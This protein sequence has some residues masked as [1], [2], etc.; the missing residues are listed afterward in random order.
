MSRDDDTIAAKLDAARSPPWL[1]ECAHEDGKP[2]AN[3]ANAMIALRGA[4]ELRDAIARDEMRVDNMLMQALP[5]T[6]EAAQLFTPRP[7][8]DI[9][10]ARIQELL[11]LAGLRRLS[12]DVLRQAIEMRGHERAFHQVRDY[13]EHLEWDLKPRL[14][15]WLPRYLGAAPSPYIA[16]VGTMFLIAMV[17]RVMRPG[18]KADYMLVLEGPQGVGKSSACRILGGDWYSDNLPSLE[19]GKEA[20]QHLRGLWLVEV[21]EL[22]AFGRS[23]SAI[24]KSFI[25]RQAERYRPPHGHLEVTEP[26]QC[27]LIGTVND[28]LALRD[29][30][31][32]RRFWPVPVGSIDLDALAE[33]R[34]QLFAEALHMYREGR[35][36]YPDRDFE[37][38]HIKPVQADRLEGDALEEVVADLLRHTSRTTTAELIQRLGE[39]NP[40][41]VP[42]DAARRIA[43]ILQRQGWACRKTGGRMLWECVR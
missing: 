25:T 27:V 38:E 6:R 33:D 3:L 34:D 1:A 29:D 14:D 24:L 13:L 16:E 19:T 41:R 40:L 31:G 28:R 20:A 21:G 23:E 37:A 26:R 12:R 5:G 30:T 4:P 11:Q 22:A 2:L 43:A 17:A 10:I 8:T 7:V 15:H 42:R 9:D 35:K 36:C 32:G 18:C 39:E